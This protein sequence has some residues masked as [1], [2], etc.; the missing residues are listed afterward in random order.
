[1]KPQRR[2]DKSEPQ[3]D[4]DIAVIFS[5]QLP[6][7][8]SFLKGL[9]FQYARLAGYQIDESKNSQLPSLRQ[10][11]AQKHIGQTF[12]ENSE[13]SSL[14][15][16]KKLERRKKKRTHWNNATLPMQRLWHPIF[17]EIA[18]QLFSFFFFCFSIPEVSI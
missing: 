13:M 18:F 16:S 12:K 17:R 11:F 5:P 1:M 9:R 14:R 6:P 3:S 2:G 8:F 4:G 7:L 15:Q 10:N